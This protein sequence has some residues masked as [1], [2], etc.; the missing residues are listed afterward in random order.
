MNS[1]VLV[2]IMRFIGLVLLQVIVL[3]GLSFD[4]NTF[5]GYFH[6]IIY[7][8]FILLL[9]HDIPNW[10]LLLLG[11]LIG[12]SV[13]IFYGSIGVHA[14]AAVLTSAIR[15]FI[16]KILEPKGGYVPGQSPTRYR[17][18]TAMYLRY[19]SILFGVHILWYFSMEL[20][21]I[22]YLDKILIRSIVTFFVSMPIVIIHAF[23]INP[24]N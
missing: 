24:K 14:A 23:L 6:I 20:F 18:G 21:T 11:F 22:A 5:W 19:T 8:L 10:A 7:P 3:Q 9:P 17:L 12:I 13:D 4:N 1:I 15:P 16:L 2:N